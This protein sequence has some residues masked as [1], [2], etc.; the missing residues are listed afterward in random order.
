MEGL[1]K[2]INF[3]NHLFVRTP[4][5][6]ERDLQPLLGM[7][8]HA[9]RII[10]QGRAFVSRLL[11]LLPLYQDSDSVVKLQADARADLIMWDQFLCDCNGISVFILQSSDGSP[12]VF[13]D[14]AALVGFAEIFGHESLAPGGF[15]SAEVCSYFGINQNVSN[16]GGSSHMGSSFVRQLSHLLYG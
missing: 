5:C 14:A 1:T 2:V 3:S 13:S 12:R 8:N 7:L 4:L 6:S 11:A 15:L 9:M 10:P 16:S